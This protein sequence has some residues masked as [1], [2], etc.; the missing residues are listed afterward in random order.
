MPPH[1]GRNGLH[2][3]FLQGQRGTSAVAAVPRAPPSGPVYKLEGEGWREGI[4][5]MDVNMES[6]CKD[7]CACGGVECFYGGKDIVCGMMTAMDLPV[8]RA[9]LPRTACRAL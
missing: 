7:A 6:E 9:T 5:K 2:G 1:L 4:V 8:Y 3:R